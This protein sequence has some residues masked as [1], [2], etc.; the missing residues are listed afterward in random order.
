M[1][2]MARRGRAGLPPV[3]TVNGRPLSVTELAR[4]LCVRNHPT[5]DT[6]GQ[7]VPCAIHMVQATNCYVLITAEG[8]HSFE[9]VRDVR[10]EFDIDAVAH[11][12]NRVH[13]G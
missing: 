4:R 12:Q 7:P 1:G 11:Q 9:V 10:D 5:L 8:T 13:H 6:T 3:S 2:G